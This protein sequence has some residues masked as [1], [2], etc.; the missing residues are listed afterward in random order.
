MLRVPVC[1]VHGIEV[2]IGLRWIAFG[3]NNMMWRSAGLMHVEKALK[4]N[5]AVTSLACA[6]GVWR[7]FFVA[8][9]THFFYTPSSDLCSSLCRV[10]L[11]CFRK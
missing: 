2:K 6:F 8:T 7:Y 9:A 4:L 11:A 5:E 1:T 10:S 3:K